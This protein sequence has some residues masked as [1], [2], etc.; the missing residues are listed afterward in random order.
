MAKSQVINHM[1]SLVEAGKLNPLDVI[2]YE[3]QGELA[4]ATAQLVSQHAAGGNN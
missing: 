1:T 4:P 2:K 3:S